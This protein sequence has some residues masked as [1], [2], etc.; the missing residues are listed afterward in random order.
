MK[1]S[2]TLIIQSIMKQSQ[3]NDILNFPIKE[4]GPRQPQRADKRHSE[5]AMKKRKVEIS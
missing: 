1:K 3:S 4:E 5:E 2:N